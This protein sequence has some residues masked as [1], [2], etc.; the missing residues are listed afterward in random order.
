MLSGANASY[1]CEFDLINVFLR[2]FLPQFQIYL[3]EF[4]SCRF[5]VRRTRMRDDGEQSHFANE[6]T[7]ELSNVWGNSVVASLAIFV[8]IS[9]AIEIIM[10][11]VNEHDYLRCC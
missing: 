5:T 10:M 3:F 6:F 8:V 2:L 11:T 9:E 7:S 1:D 4:L